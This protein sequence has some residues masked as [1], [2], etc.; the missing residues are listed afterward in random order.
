[1]RGIGL[2]ARAF[3]EMHLFVVSVT[4]RF[5]PVQLVLTTR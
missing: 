1:M 4:H 2:E 3:V 5:V